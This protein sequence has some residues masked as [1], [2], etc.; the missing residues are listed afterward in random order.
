MRLH[1]IRGGFQSNVLS[2]AVNVTQWELQLEV[3][4]VEVTTLQGGLTDEAKWEDYVAGSTG[5]TGTW[6]G[7]VESS[8]APNPNLF[9]SVPWQATFICPFDPGPDPPGNWPIQ[10]WQ[11]TVWL[12]QLTYEN[13]RDNAVRYTGTMRGT[14]VLTFPAT[15]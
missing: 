3:E 11:G 7:F 13:A 5:F 6:E 4:T 10:Q 14:A 15:S 8:A 2:L 12:G 1:G 9:M